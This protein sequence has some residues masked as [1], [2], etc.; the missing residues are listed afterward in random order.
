MLDLHSHTTF[1]FDGRQEPEEA[2]RRA[3]ELGCKVFGFSE[4][5]DYDYVVNGMQVCLTDVEAYYK[6][7]QTLKQKYADRITLLCGLECGFDLMAQGYYKGLFEK[8]SFDYCINSVHVLE[9]KDLYF[10]E[11]F[12]RKSKKQAYGEYLKLII[13]SLDACYDYHIIGHIGYATRNA[14]YPDRKMNYSE[15]P[16]L[17]DEMLKKIISFDK[18]IEVNTNVEGEES[19][20]PSFEIMERYRELGGRLITFGSDCHSL[21]RIMDGYAF[22]V[23]KLKCI[24]FSELCY[25]EKG[26]LRLFKI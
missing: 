20:L 23:K 6:N 10:A 17:I 8:Y 22:V 13:E 26:E 5:L 21:N 16:G 11:A 14:P 4:H 24:G 1:S 18:A 7:V 19:C 12:M 3:I 15:F 2:V 9:K 25:F